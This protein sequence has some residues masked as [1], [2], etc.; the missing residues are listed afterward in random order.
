MNPIINSRSVYP[1]HSIKLTHPRPRLAQVSLPPGNHQLIPTKGDNNYV[2]GIYLYKGLEWLDRR[3]IVSKVRS[4]RTL[5]TC[6]DFGLSAFVQ[7]EQNYKVASTTY[8]DLGAA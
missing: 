2:N 3:H 6:G 8:N 5:A 7:R 1:V 4:F